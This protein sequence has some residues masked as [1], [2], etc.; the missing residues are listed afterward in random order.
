ML[1]GRSGGG[2]AEHIDRNTDLARPAEL[3]RKRCTSS[4]SGNYNA[5]LEQLNGLDI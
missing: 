5:Y 1:S 3:D 4:P 2:K